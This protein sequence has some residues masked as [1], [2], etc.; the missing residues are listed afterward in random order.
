MENSKSPDKRTSTRV[1]LRTN[2]RKRAISP[3]KSK[4]SSKRTR[5]TKSSKTSRQASTTNAKVCVP[6]WNDASKDWSERLW[7]PTATDLHDSEWSCWNGSSASATCN[8]WCNPTLV[9][10]PAALQM[11]MT[12]K[13]LLKT[14]L[15]SATSSLHATTAAELQGTEE[16]DTNNKLL[17][18]AHMVAIKTNSSQRQL[19][20]R[21]MGAA[22]FTYNSC[23]TCARNNTCKLNK[24]T[25][26]TTFVNN[27][28]TLVQENPWLLETP[29]EIRDKAMCEFLASY[30]TSRTKHGVGGYE[31]SYRKK[32]ATTQTCYLRH[33]NYKDGCCYLRFWKKAGVGPLQIRSGER[34]KWDGKELSNDGF[35]V[36]RRPN[37]WF[38]Q[39][40]FTKPRGETQVGGRVASLDPGVRTFQTVYD[41][42]RECMLELGG[43][44]AVLKLFERCQRMDKVQS[45]ASRQQ[46]KHRARYHLLNRVLPRL[47][48]K[49]KCAIEDIH[50]RS[51]R[52][53]CDNYDTILLPALPTSKLSVRATRR[54]RSKTVRSMLGWSHYA[55]RR[56]LV[57]KAEETGS[58]VVTVTEEFTSKTCGKCGVVR[59]TFSGKVFKCADA[60]CAL[61]T[62][63]DWN[64]ARNILLKTLSV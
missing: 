61:C 13:N 10:R 5:N 3:A 22:R 33:R 48:Y 44:G 7:C 50:R 32:K 31:M 55:F 24:K 49:M 20:R 11:S 54:L 28:S 6:F 45:A 16:T 35:I 30:F 8:S 26:R 41:P 15:Q 63:R 4:V 38:I 59:P 57:L 51:A 12:Q 25:L 19:L 47:R 42:V 9:Q 56:R 23:V 27:E 36:F 17:P 1:S 62:D 53:L 34:G 39:R 29:Y 21:W 18:R 2:K 37:L 14:S 60:S 40:V 58:R 52:L 43:D 64:G 46:T